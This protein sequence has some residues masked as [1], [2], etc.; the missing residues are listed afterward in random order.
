MSSRRLG[1]RCVDI[2]S[3]ESVN[4]S[5]SDSRVIWLARSAGML[6][7]LRLVV[8]YPGNGVIWR[9]NCMMELENTRSQYQGEECR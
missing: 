2:E 3:G 1:L 5:Q 4:D 6:E 7:V 9:V 8:N